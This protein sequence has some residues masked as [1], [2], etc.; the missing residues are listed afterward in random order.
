MKNLYI[1]ECFFHGIRN[2]YSKSAFE[3]F[4]SI[5]KYNYILTNNSLRYYG[6][7]CDREI[8]SHQGS[9]AISICFHP[10]N[11]YLYNYFFNRG[12]TI[13]SEDNA[14]NQFVKSNNPSIILKPSV[15][16]EL[17]IREN[18]GYKRMTDEIQVLENIPLDY[19]W[20]IGY[21]SFLEAYKESLDNYLYLNKKD[22]KTLKKISF[23]YKLYQCGTLSQT[24]SNHH[25]NIALIK[26]ILNKYNYNIPIINP[27]TGILY[28][29][30]EEEQKEVD[31]TIQLIKNVK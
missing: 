22:E 20:A 13:T 1:N 8:Y 3:V 19:M 9:D 21:G 14:F 31:K 2:S 7:P 25:R 28:P 29:T 27:E 6:I 24:L 17:R 15:I 23:L 12:N 4:D 16:K 5:L 30:L 10:S 26:R 11:E 18:T